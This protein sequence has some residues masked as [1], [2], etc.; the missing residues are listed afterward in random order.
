[1][2]HA[3]AMY[4]SFHADQLTYSSVAEG[5]ASLPL[6]KRFGAQAEWMVLTPCTLVGAESLRF[7]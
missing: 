1:M 4:I 6:W 5:R 7:L 2:L 3:L